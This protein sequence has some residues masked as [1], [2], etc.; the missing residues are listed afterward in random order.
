MS[1][2]F[3]YDKLVQALASITHARISCLFNGVFMM[4]VSTTGFVKCP[5]LPLTLPVACPLADLEGGGGGGQAAP[6]FFSPKI[7]HIHVLLVKLKV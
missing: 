4:T 2:Y 1:W 6:A 7:Y 3:L 5:L